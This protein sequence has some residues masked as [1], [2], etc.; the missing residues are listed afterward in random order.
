VERL[1]NKEKK[2]YDENPIKSSQICVII[3]FFLHLIIESLQKRKCQVTVQTSL[4]TWIFYC[5]IG[6]EKNW[7]TARIARWHIFK[8]KVPIW[9]NF[10]G[11]WEGKWWDIL[12]PIGIYYGHLLYTYLCPFGNLVY[13]TPVWYIVETQIWQPCSRPDM[14]MEDWCAKLFRCDATHCCK[15]FIICSLPKC[16][17]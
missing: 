1:R 5:L 11:P 7:I 15:F 8:P 2:Y 16:Q 10:V 9:E 12:W 6:L 13:F 3:F 4:M 14:S 17:Q